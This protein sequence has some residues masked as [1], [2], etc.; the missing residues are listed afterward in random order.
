MR[1]LIAA[2]GRLKPGPERELFAHYLSRAESLGRKL[3]LAPFTAV[4]I[5]EAKGASSS[6]RCRNEAQSLLAKVPAGHRLLSLDRSGSQLSSED[7]AQLLA[8]YRD[9]GV[10]GVAF[11][12]GGPDGLGQ[13]VLA[14]PGQALSLGPMTLPHGLARI[15]LAEQIYRAETILAGHPYHRP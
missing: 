13:E 5:A 10:P 2:V 4:E 9:E 7:F 1:M 14:A 11:V 8:K 3:G 15:V 12:I 6:V